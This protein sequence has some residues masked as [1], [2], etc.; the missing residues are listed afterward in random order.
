MKA[1]GELPE[2][3]EVDINDILYTISTWQVEATSGHNDGWVVESYQHKINKVQEALDRI[4]KP[5]VVT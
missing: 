4:N 5:K 3:K 1:V 2:V